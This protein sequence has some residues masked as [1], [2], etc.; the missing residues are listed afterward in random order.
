MRECGTVGVA[1]AGM[2]ETVCCGGWGWHRVMG[3]NEKEN[4]DR[5]CPHVT[6]SV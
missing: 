2:G 1:G 4:K 6:V 5:E 3:A